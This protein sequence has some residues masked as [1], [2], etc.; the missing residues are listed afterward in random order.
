M[1]GKAGAVR[2]GK[3]YR[4]YYCSRAVR[5]RGLCSVYNGH[6]TLKLE[7]AILEYLGQFS[8][9]VKVREHLI[10]VERKELERHEV[11]LRDVEKRL[12]DLQD[13]FLQRLDDLLKRG[14]LTEQEFA[15]AN[16]TARE[17]TKVLETRKIE[18]QAW[19]EQEHTRASLAEKIPRLVMNFMEAFQAMDSRKQKAQLQTI[20]KAAMVYRDGRI[21][22]EFRG[23]Y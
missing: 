13:L 1:T 23:S 22:L 9:P 10:A 18:L 4:N 14:V 3:R 2:K 8:D 7:K 15:R 12:A 17:Q 6:S 20:L 19:L 11:E 16:E 5:S 21:E